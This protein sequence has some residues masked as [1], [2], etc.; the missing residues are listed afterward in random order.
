MRQRQ[1][2]CLMLLMASMVAVG[3]KKVVKEELWPNGEPMAAWFSDTTKVKV[4]DLGRQYVLTDYGVRQGTTDIQTKAIQAVIDRAAQEGGGV[5]V[6]PKGTF[7]SGSLFF[8]QGTHLHLQ[9]GAVLK[10]S[11]RIRDFE[12]RETRIEGQTCKYFVALVNADGIDGFT[13]TGKGTIDG[14]GESYWEQFWIRR[15][16]NRQCT[17]KDEMRPRLTYISNCKNVTVQDVRLIN[18][19]FWTNH[20][21]RSDHVRYLDLYIYSS[22]Q[23]IKGPSTDAVDIDVCH[24]VIV[25]GCYMNVNDDAVVLKGGKGTFADKAPEN[26]PCYN[27]LVEDCHYGT[28][29]GC[30]TLGSESVHDWNVIMRR[31]HADN[32]FNVLWLKMRPDTPQ[33]Y[34]FVR[35]ENFTGNCRSFLLVKPWTQFY[36]KQEREDMPLSQCNNISFKDIKMN[37][38][39]FF[40][41]RTSDKFALKS[42]SFENIDVKDEAKNGQ[43]SAKVIDDTRVSN[44]VVNGKRIDQ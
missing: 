32:T 24:D 29:H 39:T 5:V 38:G 10:G 37:C 22:T 7:F 11:D 17:N 36:E 26:G 6:V 27:I 40:D 41:V 34:E 1:L 44:L 33:H 28:V 3:K 23:D 30:M 12:I 8:R 20:V 4:Q 18:S 15:Q 21:Y 43:F 25:R 13:I 31:C 19:P 14:N 16:W 42:F 9:E 35:V 2:L